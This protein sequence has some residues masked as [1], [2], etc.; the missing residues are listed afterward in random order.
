VRAGEVELRT[1]VLWNF[2]AGLTGAVVL[3]LVLRC[4][5]S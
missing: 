2:L 4:I 1:P 3:A 5:A